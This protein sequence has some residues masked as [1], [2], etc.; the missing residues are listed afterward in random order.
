MFV[1]VFLFG[2]ETYYLIASRSSSRP[3][4]LESE[5]LFG[6]GGVDVLDGDAALDAAEREASGLLG[7]LVAEDGDAAVL[8]LQRRLHA[9]ELRRLAF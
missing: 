4:T 6:V 5:V 7:L 2:Y 8:V 3:M 9:L 1:P